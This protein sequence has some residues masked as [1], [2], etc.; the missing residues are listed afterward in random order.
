MVLKKK[1]LQIKIR[2]FSGW[3]PKFWIC[4][5]DFWHLIYT[6]NWQFLIYFYVSLV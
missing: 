1:E 4:W 6:G 3:V 2:P 5:E